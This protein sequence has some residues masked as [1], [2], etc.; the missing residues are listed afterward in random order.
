MKGKLIST[1][2]AAEKKR[3]WTVSNIYITP[4]ILKDPKALHKPHM[5]VTS[6]SAEYGR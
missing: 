1:V 2:C 6:A 4:F 5:E 3:E